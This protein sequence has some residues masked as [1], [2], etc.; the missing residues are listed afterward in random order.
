MASI[1]RTIGFITPFISFEPG[2][3][4]GKVGNQP[5]EKHSTS[6][7]VDNDDDYNDDDDDKDYDNVD[8][9]GPGK[10]GNKA[11]KAE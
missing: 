11:W 4:S 8:D 5:L 1:L 10:V 9:D 6:S 3:R 2:V 7:D